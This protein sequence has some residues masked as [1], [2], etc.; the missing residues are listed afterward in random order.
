MICKA[1]AETELFRTLVWLTVGD[2]LKGGWYEKERSNHLI[3]GD[4]EHGRHFSWMC[5]YAG[6]D[7]G[8]VRKRVNK[9][10][11]VKLPSWTLVNLGRNVLG[12]WGKIN[13]K[14]QRVKRKRA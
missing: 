4:G 10:K 11:D 14:Q 6:Y 1:M 9:V 5:D 2:Y 3:F 13:C 8:Y 12:E 7:V